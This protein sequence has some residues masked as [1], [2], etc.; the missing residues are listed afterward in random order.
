MLTLVE[1]PSWEGS[2][3]GRLMESLRDLTFAHSNHEP[4]TTNFCCICNKRL[5]RLRRRLTW[6][7]FS[8]FLACVRVELSHR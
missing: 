3:V 8:D 5:H 7:E 6:S 4:V 2:G 1:F